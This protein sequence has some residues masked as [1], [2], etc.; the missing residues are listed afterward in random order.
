MYMSTEYNLMTWITNIPVLCK[1]DVLIWI[2]LNKSHITRVL[3]S[4]GILTATLDLS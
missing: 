3:L 4:Q 1:N 2:E